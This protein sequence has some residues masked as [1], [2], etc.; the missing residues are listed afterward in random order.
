MVK[1]VKVPKEAPGWNPVKGAAGPDNGAGTKRRRKKKKKNNRKATATTPAPSSG[2]PPSSSGSPPSGSSSYDPC[3]EP[4]ACGPNA[5]CSPRGS[6]PACSCPDGFGGIP[7]DGTPDPAHGCVRTP[8]K[9]RAE[10]E[11]GAAL[12]GGRKGPFAGGKKT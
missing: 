7:R 9:C 4:D 3:S 10:E 5:V 2:S 11:E 8:D 6:E 1:V 12:R